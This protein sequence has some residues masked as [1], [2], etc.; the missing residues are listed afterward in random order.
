[1]FAP[2]IEFGPLR[3][4][5][6][7]TPAEMQVYSRQNAKAIRW[8]KAGRAAW[9]SAAEVGARKLEAVDGAQNGDGQAFGAEEL[10]CHRLHLLRGDGV[11]AARDFVLGDVTAKVHFLPRHVPHA[12]GGGLQAQQQASLQIVL[13]A[14]QFFLADG[15]RLQFAKL[16]EHQIDDLPRLVR[17]RARV[18]TQATGIVKAAEAGKHRV[19]QSALFANVLEQAR[20]HAAAQN[21][22]ENVRGEAVLMRLRIGGRA[23]A[24]MDLLQILLVPHLKVGMG[25][26]DGTAAQGRARGQVAEFLLD[27]IHDLGVLEVARRRR[28]A[29]CSAHSAGG[30]S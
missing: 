24:K 27:Q 4:G 2:R 29:Y 25:H 5:R 11:N 19:S 13:G 15:V 22:I 6:S 17:G 16:L 20:T 26:R 12:A 10:L 18:N 23:H 9:G 14:L 28:S 1:M 8:Q 3:S 30:S 21:R 7:C